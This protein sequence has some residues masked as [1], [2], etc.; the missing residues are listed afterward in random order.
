MS[1][2]VA[3][4]TIVRVSG[5]H[6]HDSD[7]VST[8][9]DKVVKEHHKAA[10][11]NQTINQRTVYEDVTASIMNIPATSPGLPYVPKYKTMARSIQK[12]RKTILD[13]PP[14]PKDWS[15]MQVSISVVSV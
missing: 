6:N 5:D 8:A 7:L 10:A 1:L 11:S 13:C 3:S 14:L 9:V 4:D 2:D 12:K 15:D